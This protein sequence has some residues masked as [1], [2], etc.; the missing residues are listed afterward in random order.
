[1]AFLSTVSLIGEDQ[2][3]KLFL[4]RSQLCREVNDA[5]YM[6]LAKLAI[7]VFLWHT[8]VPDNVPRKW[9]RHFVESAMNGELVS[10]EVRKFSLITE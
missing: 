6:H 9:L 10:I 8:L 3:N 2:M 7:L 4:S 1:M 5:L